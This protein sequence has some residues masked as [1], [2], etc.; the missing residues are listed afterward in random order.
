[1]CYNTQVLH[2]L[3]ISLPRS[4]CCRGPAV[5]G[6]F[7]AVDFSPVS[8]FVESAGSFLLVGVELFNQLIIILL[9]AVSTGF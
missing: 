9:L 4:H 6:R 1:M 7:W 8:V 3:F 2:F 5:L